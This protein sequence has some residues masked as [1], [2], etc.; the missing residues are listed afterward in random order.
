MRWTFADPNN[1][2]EVA[3][4]THVLQK[5]EAWW[6]AFRVRQQSI[7]ELLEQKVEWNL[8]EWMHQHLNAI[9]PPLCWEFGPAVNTEGHRLVITSESHLWA[10]QI[11]KRILKDAPELPGWEF[12]GHR[13]PETGANAELVLEGR[14]GTSLNDLQVALNIGR[15]RKIDLVW[16]VPGCTGPHD[17]EA[18][19]TAIVATETLLG[20]RMLDQ[21]VG[22]IEIAPP[23][24]RS[25]LGLG[26]ES[27]VDP[28][29]LLPPSRLKPTADALVSTIRDNLPPTPLAN[30]RDELGFSNI[31]LEPEPADAYPGRA[32][33]LFAST[34]Y[35]EMWEAA[36][37][38]SSFS[39]SCHSRHREI[40]AYLKIEAPE[41]P[42]EKSVVNRAAIEDPLHQ[43][44]MQVGAGCTIGGGTGI[45]NAYIDLAITDVKQAVVIIRQ[46]LRRQEVTQNCWLLFFDDEWEREWVGIYDT[47]PPP[48]MPAQV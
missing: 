21:W 18:F 46:L 40:F 6:G 39:S 35:F 27:A 25:L 11:V 33:L 42:N 2:D 24:E 30:V 43:A 4:R 34:G 44:L 5:T 20:E 26:K 23:P 1:S 31:E 15:G 17:N 22:V 12:Y 38:G 28:K 14:T 13:L 19:D 32:D 8:A 37:V 7:C 48:L 36:H 10:R 47:T 3:F 9:L 16:V 45:G 29:R 41:G